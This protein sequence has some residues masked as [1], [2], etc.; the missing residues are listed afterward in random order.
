[1]AEPALDACD[2]ADETALALFLDFD[3]TLVDIAPRPDDV[4]VEPGLTE[5][6]ERL[7][8][9][10]G[11]ALAIVSGRPIAVLDRYLAPHRFDSA[12]LHGV[13]RR[14]AGRVSVCRP[15]SHPRFRAAVQDLRQRFASQPGLVVED[16]DSSVALHWRLAPERAEEVKAAAE[17]A[18][19]ELGA[20]YRVQWG[21][22][23]G[24]ILP[25][26][27]GKGRAIEAFLR[28]HPY[29]GRRPIFVGDDLTDEDGFETVHGHG[30][31][32]VRVGSGSSVARHRLA[33][34]A[35]LRRCLFA[36]A[37]GD[38]VSPGLGGSA[39]PP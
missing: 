39:D 8:Q 17:A 23:V 14:I 16:K 12:G 34:P 2:R 28:S 27:A 18:V 29:R 32:S 33:A 31:I 30:G 35:D 1:M 37:A 19:A 4:A 3:G 13:E 25:A 15:E 10:L 22:A 5:A 11:G 20:E 26:A 21:K 9:R 38:A 36:W 24:E 6:L 7:R